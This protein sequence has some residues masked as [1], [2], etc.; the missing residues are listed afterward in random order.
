MFDMGSYLWLISTL[1]LAAS[2]LTAAL[3]PRVLRRHSH[4]PCVIGAVASCVLSVLVLAAVARGGEPLQRCYTWFSVSRL[5]ESTH[6]LESVDI[7]FTLQADGL[8]AIMLV[9]V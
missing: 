9:T 8:T 4:W 5:G 7:G 6:L 3:G 1:P 2:V